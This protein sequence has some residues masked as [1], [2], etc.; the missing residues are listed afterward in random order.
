MEGFSWVLVTQFLG[1]GMAGL[2]RR[3]LIRPKSMLWPSI[4]SSVALFVSFHSD[5]ALS[6]KF[7]ISRFHYFWGALALI[8]LYT[9]IPQFFLVSLQSFSLICLL[10]SNRTLKFLASASS[11][12]G[13]G[14]GA[15][16]LDLYYIGGEML[17]TPFWAT[18][19]V[20]IG[21]VFWAWIVT[22]ILYCNNF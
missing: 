20:F 10:T 9:W 12:Y 7:S 13:I 21:G 11:G 2:A 5:S 3:F 22:P 15:L 8:F 1:Y 19:N 16:T 4:L 6:S 18:L 17:T 14:L